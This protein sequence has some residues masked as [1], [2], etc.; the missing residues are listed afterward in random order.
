MSFLLAGTNG[1]GILTDGS[2][3]KFDGADAA[4]TVFSTV[5]VAFASASATR[6]P[7]P[8]EGV[9]SFPRARE[10]VRVRH[11]LR[12]L[13]AEGRRHEARPLLERLRALAEED[14]V[15]WAAMRPELA[16]WKLTLGL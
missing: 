16:R 2:D 10:L 11:E 1:G 9:M 7:L 3:E 12:R 15:E 5:S 4:L 6:R 8:P 13:L 14:A